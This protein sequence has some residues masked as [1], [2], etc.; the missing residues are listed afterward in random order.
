M[1][2]LVQLALSVPQVLKAQQAQQAFKVTKAHLVLPAPLDRWALPVPVVRLAREALQVQQ[3]S[4]R[5]AQRV[6]KVYKALR[7]R[8]V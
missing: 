5:L 2:R 4:V 8:S 7:V 3:V 6:F 1:A